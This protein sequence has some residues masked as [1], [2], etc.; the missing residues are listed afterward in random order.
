M[1]DLK[2]EVVAEDGTVAGSLDPNKVDKGFSFPSLPLINLTII[3]ELK[4]ECKTL[5]YIRSH[6]RAFGC[7]LTRNEVMW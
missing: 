5:T 2:E 3:D 4:L 7:N 6:C 1:K